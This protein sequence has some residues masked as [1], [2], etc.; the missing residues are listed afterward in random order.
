MK[1]NNKLIKRLLE[2][3]INDVNIE[4]V[5]SNLKRMKKDKISKKARRNSFKNLNQ[6]ATKMRNT[7]KHKE[8]MIKTIAT[9]KIKRKS[10]SDNNTNS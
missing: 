6:T 8:K 9:M 3:K 7:P 5:D 1:E 2:E 4:N 10:P